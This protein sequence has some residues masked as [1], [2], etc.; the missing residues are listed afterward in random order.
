[1][2]QR[3]GT[4][5]DKAQ[6]TAKVLEMAET[7]LGLMRTSRDAEGINHFAAKAA[8]CRQVHDELQALDALPAAT[9]PAFKVGDVVSVRGLTYEQRVVA[10]PDNG[11]V[12]VVMNLD[13]GGATEVYVSDCRLAAPAVPAPA[14]SLS[15][16]KRKTAQR[17]H[18]MPPF[19]DAGGR[20]SD[21]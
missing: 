3:E 17:G 19:H 16:Q 4:M 12:T 7:F 21:R 10:P 13:G 18:K 11:M 5:I 14:D 2:A 1:M 20:G 9:T 15:V 6:A 8:A